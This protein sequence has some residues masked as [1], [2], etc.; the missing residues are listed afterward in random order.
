VEGN[1]KGRRG[2]RGKRKTRGRSW[3][4]GAGGEE[5]EREVMGEGSRGRGGS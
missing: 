4:R 5:E 3:V 1:I 2:E